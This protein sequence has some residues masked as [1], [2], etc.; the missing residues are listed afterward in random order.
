VDESP[1]RV[2]IASAG[3]TSY[4]ALMAVCK[5][6]YA[7]Q[8]SYTRTEDPSNLTRPDYHSHWSA[9]KDGAWFH[10]DN[11]LELL[12]LIAMWEVRGDNWRMTE[13]DRPIM[14][15][16]DAAAKTYDPEGNEIQD[17]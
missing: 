1:R 4:P 10:A 5:K 6:G 11:P 17:D 16:I 9:N 2:N 15:A 8:L 3:N 12:G 13:A 7:V 14:E